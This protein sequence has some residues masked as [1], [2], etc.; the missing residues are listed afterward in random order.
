MQ[1]AVAY[2]AQRFHD[3]KRATLIRKSDTFKIA[4]QEAAGLHEAF[5]RAPAQ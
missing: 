2:S 5:D 3:L 1:R 4:E